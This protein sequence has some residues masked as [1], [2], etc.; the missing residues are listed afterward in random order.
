MRKAA[1]NSFNGRNLQQM[2][3]M[4]KKISILVRPKKDDHHISAALFINVNE[5]NPPG[6]SKSKYKL[7]PN[8]EVSLL[9]SGLHDRDGCHAHIYSKHLKIVLR[10]RS[11]MILKLNREHLK[12]KLF[13]L[14]R[15]NERL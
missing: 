9:V 13:K 8:N 10:T 6:W 5:S 11:L 2:T 4:S 7:S 12:F 1:R 15:N 3:I 14:D